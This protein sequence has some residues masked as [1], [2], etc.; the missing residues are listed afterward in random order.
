MGHEPID[1]ASTLSSLAH[2]YRIQGKYRKAEPLYQRALAI[3]ERAQG[4]NKITIAKASNNLSLL[5]LEQKRYE[6]A[7]P[8]FQQAL[9][10]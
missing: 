7:E 9:A 6:E 2:L 3:A 5:C 10:L 1:L 8:L 4:P